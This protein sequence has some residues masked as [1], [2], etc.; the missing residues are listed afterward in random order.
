MLSVDNIRAFLKFAFVLFCY[1]TN[2]LMTGPL[3][4][5]EFCFP[6]ISIFPSTSQFTSRPLSV[7]LGPVYMEGGCP[8]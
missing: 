4:N 5:S 2:H 7:N 6:G 8:G 1:I 3:G